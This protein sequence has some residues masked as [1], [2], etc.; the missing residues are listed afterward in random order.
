MPLLLLFGC[1]L[2]KR[3]SRHDAHKGTAE[4]KGAQAEESF[5][6]VLFVNI[7]LDKVSRYYQE[8]GVMRSRK[9]ARFPRKIFFKG[10]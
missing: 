4:R 3:V 5:R 8:D 7:F 9:C 1:C 10:G 2:M 6:E